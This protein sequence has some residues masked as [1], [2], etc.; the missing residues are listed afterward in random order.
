MVAGIMGVYKISILET[1]DKY[2]QIGQV[3]NW[4]SIYS[5]QKQQ[6]GQIIKRIFVYLK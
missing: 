6:P 4:Y 3:Q 1:L 2:G 5:R